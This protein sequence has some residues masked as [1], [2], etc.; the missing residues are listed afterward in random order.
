MRFDKTINNLNPKIPDKKTTLPKISE[1][2]S[3]IIYTLSTVTYLVPH[4]CRLLRVVRI[5][6]LA[7]FKIK[8]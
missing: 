8:K 2:N 1:Y 7:F 5:G 4:T 6:L 3:N